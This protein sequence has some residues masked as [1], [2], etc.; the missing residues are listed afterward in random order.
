MAKHAWEIL[1]GL[2]TKVGWV[3]HHFG[4]EALI[5]TYLSDFFKKYCT[6][7]KAAAE[8]TKQLS[9]EIFC[10]NMTCTRPTQNGVMDT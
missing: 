8:E 9:E 1:K 4:L 2:Y 7:Y 6:K 3:S 10:L 5:D